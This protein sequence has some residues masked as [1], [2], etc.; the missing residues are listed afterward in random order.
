M[1]WRCRVVRVTSGQ[2]LSLLG[3]LGRGNLGLFLKPWCQPPAV[4]SLP[5]PPFAPQKG[6][7]PWPFTLVYSFV[8]FLAD[9][10]EDA[11]YVGFDFVVPEA[12]DAVAGVFEVLG[13]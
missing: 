6:R 11:F 3:G 5:R 12:E 1:G 13:Y 2:W 9:C 10:V 7:E 4:A 8:Q